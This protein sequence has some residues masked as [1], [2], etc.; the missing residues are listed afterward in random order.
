MKSQET[1][2]VIMKEDKATLVTTFGLRIGTRRQITSGRRLALSA[3]THWIWLL[4][5]GLTDLCL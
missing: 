5:D 2:T 4:M 1:R 3:L